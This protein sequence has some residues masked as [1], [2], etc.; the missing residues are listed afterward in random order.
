MG[1]GERKLKK[2]RHDATCALITSSYIMAQGIFRLCS[3]DSSPVQSGSQLK[4]AKS[5]NGNVR[6]QSAFQIRSSSNSHYPFITPSQLLL[7]RLQ[8][9]ELWRRDFSILRD[10]ASRILRDH[11]R[12]PMI[13]HHPPALHRPPSW[14]RSPSE[15][16]PQPQPHNPRA[17]SPPSPAAAREAAKD[18]SQ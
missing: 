14:H 3:P 9:E 11:S 13:S 8:T 6:T 17:S 1:R 2:T 10:L 18:E 5:D 16:Q 12:Q 7:R 4:L 15:A